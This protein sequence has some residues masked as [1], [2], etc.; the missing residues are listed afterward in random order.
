MEEKDVL[1]A[2]GEQWVITNSLCDG[3]VPYA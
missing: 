3:T 2:D 1:L